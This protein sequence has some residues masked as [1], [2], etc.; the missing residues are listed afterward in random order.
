MSV[1]ESAVLIDVSGPE[2]VC[3]VNGAWTVDALRSRR[4]Q[5]RRSRA[6]QRV[7]GSAAWDLSGVTALD[8]VGALML[9]QAWGNRLPE[10]ATLP[11]GTSQSAFD[12][13]PAFVSDGTDTTRCR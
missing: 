10:K 11:E 4:E 8:S 3:R 7:D 1:D 9:W 6:L 12:A 13:S 2:P 5:E